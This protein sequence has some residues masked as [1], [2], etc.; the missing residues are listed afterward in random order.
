MHNEVL[1]YRGNEVESKHAFNYV[2]STSDGKLSSGSSAIDSMIFPRSAIK[3]FQV[4][5]F[6]TSGAFSATKST[7][8]EISIAC[9]SHNAENVH[10]SCVSAW[11][12]NNQLTSKSLVCGSGLPR[13][14]DDVKYVYENKILLNPTYN[15][16]SGKHSAMLL[17]CKH[18]GWD[19]SSYHLATH[20][21]QKQILQVLESFCGHKLDENRVGIDGCALPNY[22][23]SLKDLSVAAAKFAAYAEKNTN[24]TEKACHQVLT[25]I[26]KYPYMI[27]GR[28]RL[29]TDLAAVTEGRIIAKVGAEGVYMA[30]IR[31]QKLGIT[32]KVDDG[33]FRAVEVALVHLLKKYSLLKDSETK[34]LAKWFEIPIFNTLNERVGKVSANL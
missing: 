7:D 16:C 4:L 8:K 32:L 20:P 19:L 11:L 2:I 31:D 1:V 3:L 30:I 17:T 10:V 23:M 6:I 28:E 34:S 9:G 21:L 25:A 24:D 27:A 18:M 26:Y 29:C 13:L 33:S 15:N 14:N 22:M 12:E 5:P